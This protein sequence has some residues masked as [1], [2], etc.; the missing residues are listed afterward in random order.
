MADKSECYVPLSSCPF[1]GHALD[2]CFT[3]NGS[4][5]RPGM[6]LVCIYCA[7]I[8]LLRSDLKPRKPTR[9]ELEAL[10]CFSIWPDVQRTQALVKERNANP[11][12]ELL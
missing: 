11:G 10:R 7:K 9:P 6:F 8:L 3:A 1:C 2:F 12:V 4:D 5:V